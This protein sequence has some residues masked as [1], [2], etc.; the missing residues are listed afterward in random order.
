MADVRT[1]SQQIRFLFTAVTLLCVLLLNNQEITTYYPASKVNTQ[2]H[3]AAAD[4]DQ[5]VVKQKVSFEATT[6]Y[7][8][9]QIEPFTAWLRPDPIGYTPAINTPWLVSKVGRL[10]H[11]FGIFFAFTIVPNAP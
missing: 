9:L 1:I 7:L 4:K 8:V 2:V 3:T 10:I 11:F 5:T 6:S